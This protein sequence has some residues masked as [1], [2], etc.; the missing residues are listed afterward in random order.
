[1]TWHESDI[2]VSVDIVWKDPEQN[3]KMLNISLIIDLTKL[4]TYI[5]KKKK[6]KKKSVCYSLYSLFSIMWFCK[7]LGINSHQSNST[8]SHTLILPLTEKKKTRVLWLSVYLD[9]DK[10]FKTTWTVEG[11][12]LQLYIHKRFLCACCYQICQ[13]MSTP[14]FSSVLYLSIMTPWGMK[15]QSRSPE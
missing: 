13:H 11:L 4:W 6:K 10:R 5:K 3:D 1:M 7:K 8:L 2:V 14:A 9:A 12:W 15:T